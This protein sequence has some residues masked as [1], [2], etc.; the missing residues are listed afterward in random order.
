MT[1]ITGDWTKSSYSFA[2]GNCLEARWAAS[3]H[4]GDT[5]CVQARAAAGAVQVRDSKNPEGGILSFAP[6]A[7]EAFLADLKAAPGTA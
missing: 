7:W 3:V 4:S 1:A 6:A 2:N 5:N